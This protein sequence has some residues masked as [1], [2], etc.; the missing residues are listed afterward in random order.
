MKMTRKWME[1]AYSGKWKEKQKMDFDKK[2]NEKNEPEMDLP[3]GQ[4]TPEQMEEYLKGGGLLGMLNRTL[5]KK[6]DK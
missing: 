6:E 4:M 5:T 2:M 1:W 3:M